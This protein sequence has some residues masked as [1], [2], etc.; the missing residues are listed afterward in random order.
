MEERL[1]W[2]ERAVLGRVLGGHAG[3]WRRSQRG[4]SLLCERTDKQ[5]RVEKEYRSVCVSRSFTRMPDERELWSKLR[6]CRGPAAV[7]S[8]GAVLVVVEPSLVRGWAL[9][10]NAEKI[11]YPFGNVLLCVMEQVSGLD[12]S[13][14][15][16]V[17]L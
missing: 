1:A 11:I 9:S 6:H 7:A 10:N 17:E 4:D 16:L 14:Y 13:T 5:I 8:P 15:E 2:R 3:R 12:G